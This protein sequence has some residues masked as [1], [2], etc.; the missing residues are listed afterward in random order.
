M[1]F[2][3]REASRRRPSQVPPGASNGSSSATIIRGEGYIASRNLPRSIPEASRRGGDRGHRSD[4]LV[5]AV[6]GLPRESLVVRLHEDLAALIEGEFRLA[7][8]DQHDLHVAHV[9]ALGAQALGGLRQ[10]HP[11]RLLEGRNESRR[12]PARFE[13][14]VRHR[15]DLGLGGTG[16]AD[17]SPFKFSAATPA[18]QEV[19][20]RSESIFASS[21]RIWSSR[22]WV[23]GFG[24]PSRSQIS[25][26][27]E[28]S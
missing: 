19:V 2:P 25:G 22:A 4:G 10:V 23:A 24:G 15:T 9:P 11:L 26:P 1:R 12:G 16:T 21:A 5:D 18:R 8:E 13:Q 7:L 28:T 3:Q 27:F 17:P 20:R 6:D 14:I